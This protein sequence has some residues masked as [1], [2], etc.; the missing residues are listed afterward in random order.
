MMMSIRPE[1]RRDPYEAARKQA[2]ALLARAFGKG[3]ADDAGGYVRGEANQDDERELGGGLDSGQD[4][5][6]WDLAD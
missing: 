6:S 4:Q 1:D 3:R 5:A 2:R